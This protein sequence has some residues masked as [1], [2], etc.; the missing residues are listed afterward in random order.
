[1]SSALSITQ[2]VKPPRAVFVDF[3][4]GHTSGKP[5]A[6]RAQDSLLERTLAAFEAINTAGEIRI[7][8]DCW[9]ADDSWKM[10]LLAPGDDART[11][12]Q[13]QPQYQSDEDARL[14]AEALARG[15][16]CPSCVWLADRLADGLA[17]RLA[18]RLAD[19]SPND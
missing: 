16:G 10:P 18:D 4:L 19:G 3:P 13:D 14:A 6:E 17:D 7:F 5:L 1:M 15:D 11:D 8:D 12:R 2:S 9:G